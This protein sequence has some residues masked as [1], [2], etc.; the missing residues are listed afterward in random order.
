MRP[1]LHYV[2]EDRVLA[3][4]G[5]VMVLTCA[6]R[7][8]AQRIEGWR[9]CSKT[10]LRGKAMID[11]IDLEAL[12]RIPQISYYFRYPL[13]RE[14]FHELK[15]RETL[16]G[17]YAAKP[18]YGRLTPSG[19][20]DRSAGYNGEVAALYLPVH[21]RSADDARVLQTHIDPTDV[22]LPSGRRNWSC[23]RAAAE[24]VI[25]LAISKNRTRH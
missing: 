23:I 2:R 7:P 20:V 9:T 12:R 22:A 10:K 18:L 19:H 1:L 25:R 8:N 24:Q 15:V 4:G 14:N 3:V 13:H 5:I 21:A 6:S 11:D 17:H 16:R